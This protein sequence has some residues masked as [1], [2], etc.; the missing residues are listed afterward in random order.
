MPVC[1]VC[2]TE[3][4]PG[5]RFCGACG[6]PLGADPSLTRTTPPDEQL[7]LRVVPGPVPTPSVRTRL[8]S[9]A[10]GL[11]PG[12][13]VAGRYR[14]V[15][16]VGQG[17]M[18]EVYRADDLTLGQPVALKFLPASLDPHSDRF[19]R[20]LAE[21]RTARQVSHPNVCRVYDIV[22]SEGRTFLAMEYVDGEDLSSLLRRIGRLPSD[23]ATEIARQLCAGLAAAHD[24]G[25]LHRDL[26]PANVML[27][28]RGRARLA[29]FGLAGAEDVDL[30]LAGTPAY[31]A[32]EQLRGEPASMRS[33]VYALG[34]VLYE[35]FTGRRLFDASSIAALRDL[36]DRT[37]VA[38]LSTGL[39]EV[40]PAVDRVIRRCLDR[41]PSKR[42]ASALAVAAAL[43]GGDPLAAALAA[44]ETPAP[45]LVAAA[46]G[47][48]VLQP[49]VAIALLSAVVLL[50]PICAALQPS[51]RHY[52][53]SPVDPPDVMASRARDLLH[54]VAD[55]DPPADSARWFD[56]DDDVIRWIAAREAWS[57]QLASGWPSPVTFWYRD[58]P[59][60]LE[61]AAAFGP[62]G[63]VISSD[64]PPTTASGMR[65]VRFD[66]RGHLLELAVVPPTVETDAAGPVIA[67]QDW[68]PLFAAAGLDLSTFTPVAPRWLPPFAFDQR[69]SWSGPAPEQRDTP[70]RVEAAAYHGRPV[71]FGVFGPW[72]RPARQVASPVTAGGRA[73][74]IVEATIFLL[75]LAGCAVL[76]RRN[77]RLGRGDRQGAWR[78]TMYLFAVGLLGW[79]FGGT[80]V[81][82]LHEL[83]LF[84]SAAGGSLFVSALIGAAYLGL[85]PIV[86]R[87]WPHVIIGWS[88]VLSGSIF[89]ALVGR[90][91][92]IGVAVGLLIETSQH[93]VFL[94]YHPS[95]A[96]S[97]GLYL[98]FPLMALTSLRG[99]LAV[100][101]VEQFFAIGISLAI[102][103][104]YVT[105]YVVMRRHWLAGGVIVG[106]LNLLNGDPPLG[107]VW[108]ALYM[109]ALV[110][111]LIRFG[112]LAI[113]AAWYTGGLLADSPITTDFTQ[114]YASTGLIAVVAILALA[115]WAF[116][117]SL[118]G[119]PV[120]K[121]T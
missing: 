49:A 47:K 94:L 58:S 34:L 61:P 25:V 43:P 87:R 5:Q 77:L 59:A 39:T 22:Q 89:N 60:V 56:V 50:L 76:A 100:L 84:C 113:I 101:S 7:P 96:S 110:V 67:A 4:S 55:A 71:W 12:T 9:D 11:A 19:A 42:P 21:V 80:H 44:G 114:W 108:V 75:L 35:L 8:A 29:D 20:F 15:S 2:R 30:N 111:L 26:K 86:R 69:A 112:L 116:R 38:A 98:R 95:R 106:V 3:S 36:H 14:V 70:L 24:K 33:E 64:D 18:G 93:I 79:A 37:D 90:D 28:S 63:A 92:L 46:G 85:E 68:T 54:H 102:C 13:V 52:A 51:S 83:Y 62:I 32:P 74:N 66:A 88:R 105:C 40:D 103:L 41:D 65:L 16:L 82:T 107:V 119:Q 23:K 10:D 17:G 57:V 109:T 78:L 115:V 81:P 73:A 45:A 48:G 117:T 31:M 104:I 118:G 53:L 72:S 6:A 1:P 121:E 97:G 120:F 91:L 99:A 27:D